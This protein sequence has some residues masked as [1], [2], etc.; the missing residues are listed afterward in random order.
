MYVDD[1]ARRSRILGGLGR[2]GALRRA[3]LENYLAE[4]RALAAQGGGNLWVVEPRMPPGRLPGF[5]ATVARHLTAAGV[6][7]GDVKVIAGSTS[8][9]ITILPRG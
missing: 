2:R 4:A 3:L 6:A 7:T 1:G 9:R 5:A 8:A